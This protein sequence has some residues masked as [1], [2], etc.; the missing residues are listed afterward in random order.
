MLTAFNNIIPILQVRTLRINEVKSLSQGRLARNQHTEDLNPEFILFTLPLKME[1]KTPGWLRTDFSL[2]SQQG[3]WEVLGL[4]LVRSAGSDAP[5]CWPCWSLARHVVNQLSPG[6]RQVSPWGGP[7]GKTHP[8][9]G[10]VC[11][12]S[13]W[14]EIRGG[15]GRDREKSGGKGGKRGRTEVGSHPHQ[16]LQGS[17]RQSRLPAEPPGELQ[18]HWCPGPAPRD[19]EG[20]IDLGCSLD[21]IGSF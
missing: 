17:S 1:Q 4:P 8:V 21:I 20:P 7:R 6:M 18:W 19:A 3:S 2:L 10:G 14:L 15:I 16:N 13:F 12:F 9:R 5:Y 11:F